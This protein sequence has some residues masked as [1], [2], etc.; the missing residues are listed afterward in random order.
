[1][2]NLLITGA[3][4]LLGHQICEDCLQSGHN[5]FGLVHTMP[6]SP[7]R[8]VT[9]LPI[10]LGSNWRTEDLPTHVDAI[11]HLAQSPNF[12]DFPKSALEIFRVNVESTARLLDYAKN[13]GVRKFILA[14][15]G[16]LYGMSRKAHTE[17]SSILSPEKLDYYLASKLASEM[18]T[19]NY[20][21]IFQ[22]TIL[23]FFFVY[24]LR[25]NRSML[26]PRLLDNINK[27]NKIDLQG[28]DGLH[29]NPVHVADAS[30]ATLASLET[31]ESDLINIAGPDILSIREI[32]EAMGSIL[33]ITPKFE[34]QPGG[35]AALIGD[36]QRMREKL[37]QPKIRLI[38][39]IK[40]MI[41]ANNGLAQAKTKE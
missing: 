5:L 31:N 26:I 17:T 3:N 1:M 9:Y 27:G 16:G 40:E 34:V 15:S 8:G 25:Q 38:D 13:T 7:L 22:T 37:H 2:K 36:N 30:A 39:S 11:I 10:D 41:E 29:I 6:P 35:P 18:L 12:R 14:S 24:G 21:R 33:G 19:Q 20:S 32:C 28:A 23:R 4:G